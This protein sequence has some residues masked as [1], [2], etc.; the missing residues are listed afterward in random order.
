[1]EPEDEGLMK[2]HWALN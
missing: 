2:Q 1:M